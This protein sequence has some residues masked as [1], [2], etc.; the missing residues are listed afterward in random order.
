LMESRRAMIAEDGCNQGRQK[1][2]TP[3]LVESGEAEEDD[4]IGDLMEMS[5]FAILC[6]KYAPRHR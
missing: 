5:Y 6:R 1:W 3:A 4:A 2:P